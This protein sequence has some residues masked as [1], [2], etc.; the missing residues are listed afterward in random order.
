MA[1]KRRT[2]MEMKKKRKVPKELTEKTKEFMKIRKAI[3]E[4]LK[5][6]PKT[7][8]E[9][10]R[11]IGLSLPETTYNVMSC[12]KYGYIEETGEITEDGYYK[13]SLGKRR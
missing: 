5:S 3:A 10:A 6:G 11:E 4:A 2:F 13:Y 8:P 7:I 12:R 1:K 9:I